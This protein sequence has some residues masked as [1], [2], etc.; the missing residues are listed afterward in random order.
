MNRR[1]LLGVVASLPLFS[2]LRSYAAEIRGAP[3]PP[4]LSADAL[5]LIEA[6]ADEILPSTRTPGAREAG[7]GAF[8]RL[9]I[10]HSIPPDFVSRLE[11]GMLEFR[12]EAQRVLGRPFENAASDPRRTFLADLD[13]R[14]FE[15]QPTA[16]PSGQVGFYLVVKRLTVIGYYT[17]RTGAMSQLDVSMLPGPFRGSTRK[18]GD[19]RTFYED[20]F[21]VP[22]ERPA[23][24]LL[25]H[26][27]S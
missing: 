16:Q 2:H 11:Q 14:S 5:G 17:S 15:R 24:Y 18:T 8:V 10:A 6:I 23:G 22:L 12:N 4:A 19:I 1:K 27:Q 9:M 25:S 20:S 3:R 26:E 7:V 13:R 21:G